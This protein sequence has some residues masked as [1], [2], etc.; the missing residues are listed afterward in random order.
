MR[1]ELRDVEDRVDGAE[2]AG[3]PEGV[4]ALAW[5]SDNLGR[6][7]VLLGELRGRPSAA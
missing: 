1:F 4:G 5:L 6:T 2:I 3:K 7:E